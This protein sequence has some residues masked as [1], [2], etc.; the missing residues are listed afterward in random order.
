MTHEFQARS[1]GMLVARLENHLCS[2]RLL[3]LAER[4]LFERN[5]EIPSCDI[6]KTSWENGTRSQCINFTIGIFVQT[7]K[8]MNQFL[9]D[10]DNLLIRFLE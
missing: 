5:L 2:I 6:Q 3:L 9:L 10:I 1:M 8:K 7:R 4:E